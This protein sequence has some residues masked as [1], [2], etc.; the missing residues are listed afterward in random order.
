ME[1]F[2]APLLFLL[3][4][5]ISL[6]REPRRKKIKIRTG[7]RE[8]H[9]FFWRKDSVQVTKSSNMSVTEIIP[10]TKLQKYANNDLFINIVSRIKS[11]KSALWLNEGEDE[12]ASVTP[13]DDIS[14]KTLCYLA[15]QKILE[16]DKT[17]MKK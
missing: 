17:I 14:N 10:M 3:M 2:L 9:E 5:I 12:E 13:T 6:E 16:L 15:A 4:R 7:S 1:V 8:T 11:I